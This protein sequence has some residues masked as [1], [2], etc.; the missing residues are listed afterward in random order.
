MIPNPRT[1]PGAL[2]VTDGHDTA[3]YVIEHDGSFFAYGADQILIGEFPTRRAAA[4][5]I[6]TKENTEPAS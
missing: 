6:P 2:A 1:T 5:A 3:G 4:R